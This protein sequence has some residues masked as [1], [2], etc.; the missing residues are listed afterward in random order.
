MKAEGLA[1]GVKQEQKHAV[2]QA[3][4]NQWGLKKYGSQGVW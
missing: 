3:S 1:P 4:A 2:A